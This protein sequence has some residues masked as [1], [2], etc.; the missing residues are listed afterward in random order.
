MVA[1][2]LSTM[3]QVGNSVGVVAVGLIFFDSLDSGY[4]AAMELAHVALI[5]LLAVVAALS[6]LIS[7]QRR[8][9]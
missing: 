8:D 3:Q 2:V 5:G 9:S 4:A 1:W 6:R 7:E